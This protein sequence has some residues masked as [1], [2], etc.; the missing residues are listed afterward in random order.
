MKLVDELKLVNQ[1]LDSLIK[2]NGKI[3]K[4][5]EELLQMPA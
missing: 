5:Q 4:M 2:L 1:K 3:L